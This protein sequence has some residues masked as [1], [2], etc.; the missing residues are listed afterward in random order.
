MSGTGGASSLPSST[1]VRAAADAGL[2]RKR[3]ALTL[4]GR[5]LM[6]LPLLLVLAAVIGW[7]LLDTVWL[8]FTDAKL[9]DASGN[10]VGI[11]NY[12]RA[13]RAPGFLKALGVT[14]LFTV[15]TVSIE[16]FLG[17]CVG[18]LLDMELK[19]RAF[20]RF[21]LIVPWA[22]PTVV[23]AMAWRV[24]YNPDFGALN[25]LL[26]QLGIIDRY[27]SWLGSPATALFAIA[28]ADIWKTFSLV[29]L[30]TLAG[31]QS[32]PKELREAATIDGAGFFARFRAVTLPVILLPLSIAAVLRMIEAVKV[33]DIVWVMTRGGPLDSTKSLSILIYQEAF[34]FRHAGY[35]ASLAMLSVALSLL[36]IAGYTRVLRNQPR[37]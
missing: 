17:L 36:L 16:L 15:L 23:N 9:G 25:A 31:L 3:R 7:P 8:S 14:A 10:F 12:L 5:L 34:S 26:L 11:D 30:I 27:Q 13:L 6:I 4:R 29:A 20:F 28:A 33:F 2:G 32:V 37:A 35:G 24:I 22:L 19:G 21:L 1:P 18:L